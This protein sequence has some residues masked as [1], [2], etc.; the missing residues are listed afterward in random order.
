MGIEAGSYKSSRKC[1]F[2]LTGELVDTSPHSD[3]FSLGSWRCLSC[4]VYPG[5]TG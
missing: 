1:G 2:R 5:L 3:V 4:S